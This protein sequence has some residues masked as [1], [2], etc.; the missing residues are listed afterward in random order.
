MLN[1]YDIDELKALLKKN[2]VSV[3]EHEFIIRQIEYGM[4]EF[5]VRESNANQH[6]LM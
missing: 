2:D 4:W 3:S 5:K 6:F 1:R